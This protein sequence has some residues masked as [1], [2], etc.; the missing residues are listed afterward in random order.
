MTRSKA[1]G[2]L[3]IA[4]ALALSVVLGVVAA[5]VTPAGRNE[6]AAYVTTQPVLAAALLWSYRRARR[7]AGE[8][9]DARTRTT[10]VRAWFE[11]TTMV[12]V[13]AELAVLSLRFALVPLLYAAG[14]G[15]LVPP[16]RSVRAVP[17][18]D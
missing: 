6:I 1:V 10:D 18:A 8:V 16:R 11:A 7:A 15:R 9:V 3:E 5:L 2:V 12:V 4:T 17:D 13:F 14:M